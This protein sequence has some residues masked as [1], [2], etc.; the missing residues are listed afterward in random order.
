MEYPRLATTLKNVHTQPRLLYIQ[1]CYKEITKK[2]YVSSYTTYAV[3]CPNQFTMLN[4]KNLSDDQN[5]V[6]S[7]IVLCDVSSFFLFGLPFFVIR[8]SSDQNPGV[9]QLWHLSFLLV[10]VWSCFLLEA[11]F[12]NKPQRISSL[13]DPTSVVHHHINHGGCTGA[14]Q[15]GHSLW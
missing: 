12:C 1:R 9:Q 2:V 5:Y 14:L 11:A 8:H 4:W 6:C 15:V 3:K 7:V 13:R 10:L